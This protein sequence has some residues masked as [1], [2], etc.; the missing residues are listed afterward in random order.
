[1][2]KTIYTLLAFGTLAFIASVT[3]S[4]C[5]KENPEY[6]SYRAGDKTGRQVGVISL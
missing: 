1:M 2:K 4:S 3:L 6:F 5:T